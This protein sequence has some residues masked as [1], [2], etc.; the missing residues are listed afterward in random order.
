ML[1][2]SFTTI[3]SFWMLVAQFSTS[4]I[5]YDGRERNDKNLVCWWHSV[6][7]CISYL[8]CIA[9]SIDLTHPQIGL[10][11]K[12]I[13][14]CVQLLCLSIQPLLIQIGLCNAVDL[15]DKIQ[16]ELEKWHQL[17]HTTV[18]SKKHTQHLNDQPLPAIIHWLPR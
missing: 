17:T 8:E 13:C 18:Y 3:K 6:W 2:V 7:K 10:S 16:L 4:P 1:R 5:S 11:G 15:C 12:I 9:K 14:T